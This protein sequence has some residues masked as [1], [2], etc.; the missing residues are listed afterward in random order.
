VPAINFGD[1][2][3]RGK[4]GC[5]ESAV[6]VFGETGGPNA[7]LKGRR[8]EEEE[9]TE[10]CQRVS[11]EKLLDSRTRQAWKGGDD[12]VF[13]RSRGAFA[14]QCWIAGLGTSL[15]DGSRPLSQRS[16]RAGRYGYQ[17]PTT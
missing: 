3:A 14:S 17:K 10:P 16:R 6:S 9:T 1:K 7:S 12:I 8:A 11:S 13:Q 4:L 15:N 2:R 5:G